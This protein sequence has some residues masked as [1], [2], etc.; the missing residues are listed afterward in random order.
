MIIVKLI[1]GLGNQMFQYAVGRALADAHNCDLKLDVTGFEDYK[2]RRYELNNY[3][4][5]AS[6]ASDKDI[7][8]ING[9]RTFPGLLPPSIFMENGF[10]F[11]SSVLSLTPPCY[12]AQGYWQSEKYFS[13]IRPLLLRDFSLNTAMNASNQAVMD[14]ILENQSVSLHIRRG[15]YVTN[16]IATQYHGVCSLDYYHAAIKIIAEKIKN[17]KFFIFSDDT[18]WASEN[19]K[20]GYPSYIVDIND[21]DQGIFDMALMK[22]CQYHIIANSS[23]SW[24][25]AWLNPAEDKVVVSPRNWF[26]EAPHDTRDLIPQSWI[27]L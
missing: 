21:S 9:V 1:G 7:A 15:D 17:P 6:I 4:I 11:D 19:L 3:R 13:H 2:L 14:D 12:L 8:Y 25:G 26:D 24:W 27:R 18:D 16:P 22:S 23:F 10:T 20:T 5:R